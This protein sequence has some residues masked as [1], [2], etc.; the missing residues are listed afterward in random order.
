MGSSG[1][2]LHALRVFLPNPLQE[3][4]V[5]IANRAGS[6]QFFQIFF[7]RCAVGKPD[8]RHEELHDGR[9]MSDWLPCYGKG[10]NLNLSVWPSGHLQPDPHATFHYRLSICAVDRPP[11]LVRHNSVLGVSEHATSKDIPHFDCHLVQPCRRVRLSQ[12]DETRARAFARGDCFALLR[13]ADFARQRA[14]ECRGAIPFHVGQ[15]STPYYGAGLRARHDFWTAG[16]T[17]SPCAPAAIPRAVA[18]LILALR[19]CGSGNKKKNQT[20]GNTEPIRGIRI[21]HIVLAL[22]G[23]LVRC[24]APSAALVK[25]GL[26]LNASLPSDRGQPASPFRRILRAE[27]PETRFLSPRKL[28]TDNPTERPIDALV[29]VPELRLVCRVRAGL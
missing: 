12:N 17:G 10:W 4:E 29:S 7:P 3:A 27:H 9:G 19:P 24:Y 2:G 20:N 13:R 28:S 22:L 6:L 25:A 14:I 26:L 16:K 23:I 8:A 15:V 18:R 1:T 21:P 11:K 5:R